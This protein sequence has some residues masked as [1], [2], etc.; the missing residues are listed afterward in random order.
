MFASAILPCLAGGKPVKYI[1]LEET[2][3]S[4]IKVFLGSTRVHRNMC[5]FSLGMTQLGSTS[6]EAFYVLRPPL[7]PN[8][9]AI[10]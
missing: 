7:V 3:S 10:L 2:E 9:V 6:W 1:L 4:K 5:C 8:E